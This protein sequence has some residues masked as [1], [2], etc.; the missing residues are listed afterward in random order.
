MADQSKID[1]VLSLMSEGTSLRKSCIAANVAVPTYLLWVSKDQALAERYARARDAMLDAR[2]DEIEDIADE[3][4]PM[5]AD[6]RYDNAAVQ[7]KRVRIDTRKWA[8]AKLA[9]KKYGDRVSVAGDEDSPL[10]VK[11]LTDEQIDAQITA[12]M[13]RQGLMRG[14]CT[15]PADAVIYGDID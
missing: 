14:A 11:N 6:G 8:L 12:A 4:V 13:S 1:I 3:A 5:T 10:V 2:A 9:P 15:A 7:D